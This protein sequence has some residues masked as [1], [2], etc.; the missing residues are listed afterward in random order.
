[1]LCSILNTDR[2]SVSSIIQTDCRSVNTILKPSPKNV[3]RGQ[4]TR[5][6]IVTAARKLFAKKGYER[7][8]IADVLSELNISRGALYHHFDGKEALFLAVLEAFEEEISLTTAK[9]AR[10]IADP[11]EAMRAAW[12]AWFTLARDPAVR[13]I[14]LTDA[15]SVVG[16]EKWREIDERYAF[17]L[18]K[19]SVK[20]AAATGHIRED[21]IDTFAHILLAAAS[22]VGF[23]IARAK[24]PEA[25]TKIARATVNEL[26]DRLFVTP[27]Q[28]GT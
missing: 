25:A 3:D 18:L 5:K 14:V 7:M 10:G 26:L 27:P 1:M 8:S 12:E 2:E 19:A 21:L 15:L 23:L 6:R 11:V 22:E 9:A 13:Q 24:D 28:R 4:A 20:R 16:W 17:G